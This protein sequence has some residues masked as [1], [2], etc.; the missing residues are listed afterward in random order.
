MALTKDKRT[1]CYVSNTSMCLETYFERGANSKRHTENK[2]FGNCQTGCLQYSMTNSDSTAKTFN[3]LL[4]VG[5]TTS[6]RIAAA[7]FILAKY[8][9]FP[10][11][12]WRLCLWAS[13]CLRVSFYALINFRLAEVPHQLLCGCAAASADFLFAYLPRLNQHTHTHKH[14]KYTTV[15][16]HSHKGLN[17]PT[18][19]CLAFTRIQRAAPFRSCLPWPPAPTSAHSL[20]VRFLLLPLDPRQAPS[21]NPMGQPSCQPLSPYA[22]FSDLPRCGPSFVYIYLLIQFGY[23]VCLQSQ[24]CCCSSSSTSCSLTSGAASSSTWNIEIKFTA[25]K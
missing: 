12:G 25:I 15:H 13:I 21:I 14:T 5:E 20:Y 4:R 19:S 18:L 8:L 7:L 9:R 24:T 22:D 1:N 10:T 6:S 2:I 23:I 17:H 16:T 11:A 3:C